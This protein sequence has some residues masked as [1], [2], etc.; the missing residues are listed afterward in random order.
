MASPVG[1][2]L[3]IERAN[4]HLHDLDA[5]IQAFRESDAYDIVAQEST[6]RL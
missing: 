3:K 6:A 1:S 4:H 2:R 5:A